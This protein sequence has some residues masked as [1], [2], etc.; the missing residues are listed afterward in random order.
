MGEPLVRARHLKTTLA[1]VDRSGVRDAVHATLPPG[2][3][4]AVEA[5]N[6]FEWLPAA[7][8]VALV[9]AIHGALGDAEH[10]AFSRGVIRD[11]FEG[12]LLGPLIAIALRLFPGGLMAWAH[13]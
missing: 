4:A 6:G 9:R 3:A 13:W 8:D 11:A 2:L 1:S 7:N 12:P 10:D 5:A